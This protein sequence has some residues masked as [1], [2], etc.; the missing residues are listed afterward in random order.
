MPAAVNA[1]YGATHLRMLEDVISADTL[2]TYLVISNTPI[3]APQVTVLHSIDWYNTGFGE[4]NAFSGRILGLM[5]DLVETRSRS[6]SSFRRRK[7]NT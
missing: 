1:G 2:D 6:W 7:T 4:A 5:G 3:D